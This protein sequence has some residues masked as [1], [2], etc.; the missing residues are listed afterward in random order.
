VYIRSFKLL[1]ALAVVTIVAGCTSTSAGSP[2]P[3][4]G[5]EDGADVSTP[6]STEKTSGG[7]ELPYA[8][9]PSVNNPLDSGQ[10]QQD[11]CKA[12]TASQA[13]TLGLQTPGKLDDGSLGNTCEFRVRTDRLALVEI[14]SL[15]KNPFGVSAVYQAEEDGKLEL[16]EPL[17]PVDG[18]PVVAYAALDRRDSGA[19][20]VVVG[21]S[22]EIAFE[23]ALQ[24]SAANIGKKDP[25]ETAAMVAGLV[26][27]TM[28]A[29]Q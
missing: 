26:V 16:F 11:P 17:D 22:D 2:R 24:Q 13:D 29:A 15:D 4:S 14:A 23:V 7:N 1:A 27:E 6:P 5:H 10:F 25:C 9:A 3:E 28:K 12:L 19:C 18:Y 20:A 8:G 21:V